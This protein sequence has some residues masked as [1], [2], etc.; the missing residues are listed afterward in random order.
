[1]KIRA[2]ICVYYIPRPFVVGNGVQ[3]LD[4]ESELE[5]L[6]DLMSDAVRGKIAFLKLN[7]AEEEI[8]IGRDILTKSKITLKCEIEQK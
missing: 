7:N 4:S 1:M 2:K 3:W 8:F 5:Q 6:K